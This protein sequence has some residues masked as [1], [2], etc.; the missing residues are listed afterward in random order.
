ML[1]K[2]N[3]LLG[4]QCPR[5]LWTYK[6]NKE[7]IPKI[8][9][10]AQFRFDEG[11]KVGQLA[12]Q[13]YPKGID[14]EEDFKYNLRKTKEFIKK[15]VPL[16]EPSFL[17]QDLYARADILIPK[18][19]KWDIIEV[20]SSTKVKPIN[21]QDLAFQ[22][23]V[24]EKA[25]LKIR[26]CYLMHLNKEYRLKSKL[27]VKKLFKLKDLTEE[28]KKA[29]IDIQERIDG[30]FN[31]LNGELPETNIGKQCNNPYE[32][33]LKKECW[34]YLP[35]NNVCELYWSTKKFD[36]LNQG[37]LLLKDIP[38]DFKLNDKQ[39]IQIKGKT[40]IDKENIKKWLDKLEKPVYYMDFE[41]FATAIP[42]YKGCKPYE[43]ICFQYSIHVGKEHYE[44]LAKGLRDPRKMFLNSLLKRL[45]SKGS[46]V[47]YNKSF[48]IN[49]LKELGAFYDVDVSSYISRI[50]DLMDVFRGFWFY[51]PM[52]KGSCS[53]KAVL[54]CFG[55]DYS[56]LDICCGS[57][58]SLEFFRGFSDVAVR[59][60]LLKYC[61]RDTWAE[62]VIVEGLSDLV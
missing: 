56:D 49:R 40:H 62:V 58:A 8:S 9:E 46:I 34:S 25:G 55:L 61:E 32:C 37:I 50:V 28:V 53:I 31:I 30:M 38:E 16:F 27:S 11:N 44:Y 23:N 42:R 33:V 48:E 10:D 35:K 15:G 6:N 19:K 43:Y 36:L 45:G 39:K 47:V 5:L 52:Q 3:Y 57:L 41:T 20:K 12:K 54:P 26:K 51:D 60:S 24:Y 21:I 29:S 2:S 14:I 4:L 17:T 7:N 13:L 22:R 18:G 59:K 1:T